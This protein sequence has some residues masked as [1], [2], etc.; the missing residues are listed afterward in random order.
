MGCSLLNSYCLLEVFHVLG[1]V[2][3]RMWNAVAYGCVQRP[4]DEGKGKFV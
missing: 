3:S 2:E 4:Q 1:P